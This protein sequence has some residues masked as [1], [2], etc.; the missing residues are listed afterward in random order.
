MV[1]LSP[2]LRPPRDRRRL[3]P[4]ASPVHLGAHPRPTS[5]ASCCCKRMTRSRK[6][7]QTSPDGRAEAMSTSPRGHRPGHRGL[8]RRA[9]SS[10]STSRPATARSPL[11]EPLLTLESDKATMDV[12]AEVRRNRARG[13]RVADRGF[14]VS[15]GSVLM[16]LVI[17]D[18]RRPT[19]PTAR[20][21]RRPTPRP[22]DEDRP[23]RP[24]RCARPT[25]L[26]AQRADVAVR[27]EPTPPPRRGRPPLSRSARARLPDPAATPRRS[28]RRTSASTCRADRALRHHRRGLPQRRLH[29]LQGAAAR[30]A[31]DRRGRGDGRPRGLLR[32]PRRSTCPS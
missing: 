29:P 3:W 5:A 13:C 7:I 18:G 20:T 2:V 19:R 23:P 31:G 22:D 24:R 25:T 11:E 14:R 1:P 28:G 16:T 32:R 30:R 8:H 26:H 12:P 15:Q 27:S 9:R 6:D 21:L 10:R 17:D 4:H